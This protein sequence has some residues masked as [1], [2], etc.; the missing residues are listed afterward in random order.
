[1][2]IWTIVLIAAA[3]AFFCPAEDIN[4]TPRKIIERVGATNYIGK[5]MATRSGGSPSTNAAVWTIKRIVDDGTT[6][7]ITFAFNTNA[8]GDQVSQNAWTNRAN[9]TYK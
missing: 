6:A 3:G 2:K 9:A 5:A 1:M 7:D 8:V 4:I